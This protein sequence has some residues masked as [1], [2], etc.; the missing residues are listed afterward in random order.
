MRNPVAMAAQQQRVSARIESARQPQNVASPQYDFDV[1]AY[2]NR[3]HEID[4]NVARS[5][6]E[7]ATLEA[8]DTTKCHHTMQYQTERSFVDHV[9]ENVTT[10]GTPKWGEVMKSTPNPNYNSSMPMA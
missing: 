1:S 10:D 9:K 3:I 6:A 8:L 5:S 4:K 2:L 7:A